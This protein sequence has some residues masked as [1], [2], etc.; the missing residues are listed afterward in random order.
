MPTPQDILF[1]QFAIDYGLLSDA[2]VSRCWQE[3]QAAQGR[4]EFL[5]FPEIAQRIGVLSPYQSAG[6]LV[7]IREARQRDGGVPTCGSAP[8]EPSAK[9]AAPMFPDGRAV[10]EGPLPGPAEGVKHPAAVL[11][12]VGTGA[13]TAVD[14][15]FRKA[16]GAVAVAKTVVGEYTILGELGRGGM[17]I[18]Y[19]AVQ[20]KLN[21]RVA[22]KV[23]A[24]RDLDPEA[25][26]RLKREALAAAKLNH[27]N[28]VRVYDFGEVDGLPYFAMEYVSGASLIQLVG[29]PDVTYE[30]AAR[31]ILQAAEGLGAAHD[32]GIVHRDVKPGNL[33]VTA[34]DRLLVTDF[35]LA[36]DASAATI[37]QSNQVMGT[38]RYMSPEQA[39]GL[40]DE[41]DRRTDVYSLGATLYE[42]ATG[43]PIFDEKDGHIFHQVLFRDPRSPRRH[44]P[45]IPLDLETLI[46]KATAKDAKHRYQTMRLFADDLRRFVAGEPVQARRMS[47]VERAWRGGRRHR[48]AV[49]SGA[50]AAIAVAALLLARIAEANRQREAMDLLRQARE[51]THN[52]RIDV[53]PNASIDEALAASRVA[54]GRFERALAKVERAIALDPEQPL[55]WRTKVELM[56]RTQ[57][58]DGLPQVIERWIAIAPGDAE[59]QY[60]GA[61]RFDDSTAKARAIEALDALLA[62]PGPDPWHDLALARKAVIAGDPDRTLEI[63]SGPSRPGMKTS[64]AFRLTALAHGARN[65][66][67]ERASAVAAME[68]SLAYGEGR[69]WDWV[70][71]SW[72]YR[73]SGQFEK[74]YAAAWN[75]IGHSREEA[76]VLAECGQFAAAQGNFPLAQDYCDHAVACSQSSAVTSRVHAYLHRASLLTKLGDLAG[77]SRDYAVASNLAPDDPRV[78]AKLLRF[79]ARHSPDHDPR[80]F[81]TEARQRGR[82]DP[83]ECASIDWSTF[84]S[85]AETLVDLKLDLPAEEHLRVGL[86]I[87]EH[88]PEVNYL[89]GLLGY[90]Q[91]KYKEA[92]ERLKAAWRL[93]PTRVKPLVALSKAYAKLKD[94]KGS[95][96]CLTRAIRLEP[97]NRDLYMRRAL[98]WLEGLRLDFAL[99]D[100]ERVT[101][102]S[103]IDEVESIRKAIVEGGDTAWFERLDSG[104][105]KVAI[106]ILPRL[107]DRLSDAGDKALLAS[108]PVRAGDAFERAKVI[109]PAHW[110]PRFGLA[111]VG[112]AEEKWDIVAFR[113]KEAISRGFCDEDRLRREGGLARF[114]ARPEFAAVLAKLRKEP[115]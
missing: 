55:A 38:P 95:I 6:L 68:A 91:G 28:V 40:R 18:V 102:M 16:E 50:V 25:F 114:R 46:L 7:L 83:R 60:A 5:G 52:V 98:R 94:L 29:R 19:E 26:E 21:R 10:S 96:A 24:G 104:V 80:E 58:T 93:S 4:G 3:Q 51:E 103:R 97:D 73:D 115:R 89:Y 31:L 106:E 20:L 14:P 8:S 105:Q 33:L 77:A 113:L 1:A 53:K 79:Y 47:L 44:R 13:E 76:P 65:S 27:E 84:L 17:G 22:L 70:Q 57:S 43:K 101:L 78:L 87:D 56:M 11:G 41:V 67:A 42:L 64:E 15:H 61:W 109:D 86:E 23:L 36:R 99:P 9:S 49:F 90:S 81:Y 71:L 32:A 72:W 112:A 74:A 92:A 54:F 66:A 111:L 88:D 100:V 63:L 34:D 37:T 62:R 45:D 82:L 48:K 2:E 107:A 85:V 108:D 110:R 12:A 35:G 30:R 39:N 75:A 69:F 59:A